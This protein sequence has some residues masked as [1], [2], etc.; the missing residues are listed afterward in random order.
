MIILG[1]QNT[2]KQIRTYNNKSCGE[3]EGGRVMTKISK[4]MLAAGALG[5]M[6]IAALPVASNAALADIQL[7]VTISADDGDGGGNNEKGYTWTISD[8]DGTNVNLGK[9]AVT[10]TPTPTE[11][12]GG[13]PGSGFAPIA[14]NA[15]PSTPTD[16]TTLAVN[17]YAVKFSIGY[18]SNDAATITGGTLYASGLGLTYYWGVG[19]SGGVGSFA[20]DAPGSINSL[21]GDLGEQHN[22]STPAAQYVNTLQVVTT[23]NT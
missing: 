20:S 5:V 8:K 16:A 19:A 17:T 23:K 7:T 14:Q 3:S 10:G 15:N 13:A 2:N 4:L 21:T 6:G 11:W 12:E 22:A 9:V 18:P 1:R